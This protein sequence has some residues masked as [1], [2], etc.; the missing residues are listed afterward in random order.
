MQTKLNRKRLSFIPYMVLIVAMALFTTGCNGRKESR[1]SSADTVVQAE[2][3]QLGEGSTV[4]SF[5]VTD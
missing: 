4:F 5:T 3:G 1:I 2:S